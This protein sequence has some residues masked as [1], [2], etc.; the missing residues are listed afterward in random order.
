MIAPAGPG[1]ASTAVAAKTKPNDAM[2]RATFRFLMQILPFLKARW[3]EALT[4]RMGDRRM[5][6]HRGESRWSRPPPG[7]HPANRHRHEPT[8]VHKANRFM[9]RCDG[10]AMETR[11][12]RGQPIRQDAAR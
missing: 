2:P 11:W 4:C 6:P 7:R 8:S 9:W 10:D 12:R 3:S 1:V 5:T